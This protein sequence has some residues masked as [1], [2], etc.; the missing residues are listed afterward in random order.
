MKS[1]W[2]LFLLAAVLTA[3][4]E[5]GLLFHSSGKDYIMQDVNGIYKIGDKYQVNGKWY[6][7]HEDYNYKEVGIASW[8]GDDFHKG[9]TA[10][11]ETYNMYKMTAGHKTLPLPSIVKVTNLDNGKE[12]IV[13]VNDRGPFIN[14]RIIDVSKAAAEKLGFLEYGTAKVRVE[15]MAEESKA[16]KKA[17]LDNGGKI[18]GGAP[19]SDEVVDTSE[20]IA[21]NNG[22]YASLRPD[23]RIATPQED[24]KPIFEPKKKAP[25]AKKVTKSVSPV[26]KG[27]FL[28]LGAFKNYDNAVALKKKFSNYKNVNVVSVSKSKETIYRVRLGPFTDPSE[29]VKAM[30]K[31]KSQTGHKDMRLVQEK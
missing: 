8:Y 19:I 24:N 18:V 30:D 15:I 2:C 28:Q 6:E 23:E 14:N 9:L 31:I 13:R 11:G 22:F 16:L 12:V 10:N 26:Q 17:I 20:D 21:L 25:E 29:A 7:P 5:N 4:T 1:K 27:Y 3:C